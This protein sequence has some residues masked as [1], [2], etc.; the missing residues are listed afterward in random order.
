[1][2]DLEKA[3]AEVATFDLR[4]YRKGSALGTVIGAVASGELIPRADAVKIKP[5]VWGPNFHY[6]VEG[7]IAGDFAGFWT[8]HLSDDLTTW[9]W[10]DP[11]GKTTYGFLS[12]EEAVA[13]LEAER[14]ARIRAAIEGVE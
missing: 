9:E 6:R 4:V 8:S 10:A 7:I 5:L 11:Y 3:I 2:T 1:M 13:S 14:A 12:Q